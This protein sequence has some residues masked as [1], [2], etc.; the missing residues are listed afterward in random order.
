MFCN[1]AELPANSVGLGRTQST[2][3]TVQLLDQHTDDIS[4]IMSVGFVGGVSPT[5]TVVIVPGGSGAPH[6]LGNKGVAVLQV[7]TPPA[8]AVDATPGNVSL[9]LQAQS[10]FLCVCTMLQLLL[11]RCC[12]G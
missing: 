8:Q 4:H 10:A 12:H 9:L 2:S 5:L 7:T 6:S 11:E 3:L 1:L